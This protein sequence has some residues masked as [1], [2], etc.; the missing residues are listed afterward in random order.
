MNYA[1]RLFCSSVSSIAQ[2][3]K[4]RETDK[5]TAENRPQAGAYLGLDGELLH[6]ESTI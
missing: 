2:N 5:E 4:V 1:S 3:K 6:R